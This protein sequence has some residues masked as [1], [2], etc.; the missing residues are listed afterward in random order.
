MSDVKIGCFGLSGHQIHGS[1][2]GLE[3]ARLTAFGGIDEE[4]FEKLKETRP[5]AM[6]GVDYFGGLEGLLDTDV[7]LVS[8]CSQRR[9]DQAAQCVQALDAGKHVLAEKPMATCREDLNALREAAER[10]GK[11]LWTM[12]SM[13]YYPSVRGIKQILDSGSLGTV[14][15]LYCMKSY[16]YH[17]RRPQDRGIDGGITQAAIHAISCIGHLTGKRFVEV[18]AQDTNRGNPKDGE[19]QMAMSMTARLED[20]TLASIIA[21]Y[22]NPR[23]IGYHGNDQIRIHGTNGMLELVDGATRRSLVLVEQEPT[24]FEDDESD[25]KYPQ[26]LIDAILDGTPTLLTQEAGFHY[27][28]VALSAQESA[29]SGGPVSI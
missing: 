22:C 12:T 7:D 20:G 8:F 19:F 3:R 10:S 13:V 29:T 4:A 23:S 25:P 15:Q 17:D 27:T 1:V 26:D 9:A 2:T 28:E 14:V 6:E 5:E 21:N 18:F 16:P 11:N 24:T